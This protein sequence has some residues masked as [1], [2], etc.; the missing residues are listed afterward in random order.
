VLDLTKNI[1]KVILYFLRL[2]PG[3]LEV[4]FGK[5]KSFK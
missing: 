5:C 3:V 1:S 2:G 4:Q